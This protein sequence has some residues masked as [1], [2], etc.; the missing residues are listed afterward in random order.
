MGETWFSPRT[1]DVPF[2]RSGTPPGSG[3]SNG[4]PARRRVNLAARISLSRAREGLGP[5]APQIPRHDECLHW[6]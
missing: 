2:G 3:H 6:F 4:T 5:G 1:E